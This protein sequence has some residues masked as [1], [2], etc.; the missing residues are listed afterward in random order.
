[1]FKCAKRILRYLKGTME[2]GISY[3]KGGKGNLIAFVDSDYAG[4]V[5]DRSLVLSSMRV[6]AVTAGFFHLF[7]VFKLKGPKPIISLDTGEETFC[8]IAELKVPTVF[9]LYKSHN[10]LNIWSAD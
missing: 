1:M 9:D 7:W 3:R 6:C 10:S 4:D 5:D 2:L 8:K